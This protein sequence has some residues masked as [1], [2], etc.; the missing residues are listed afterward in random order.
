MPVFSSFTFT[1][2][3]NKTDINV[4][5][6]DPDCTPR[7]I[8]QIAH[9]VA[10]HSG[11]YDGFMAFLAS[12]GFVAVAND[13]LGHG[14]SYKRIDEQGWFAEEDGWDL[15]VGDVKKLHDI[16]RKEFPD[17]PYVL[18]GHSMGSF[19]VRTYLIRYPGDADAA[20]IC[21]TGQQSPALVGAGK[22]AALLACRTRGTMR[23]SKALNAMAFGSYN[24][25]FEPRRTDFDWL[26]RDDAVVDA[27]IKDPNC[28]FAVT[29]GLFRDMMTG[30]EFISKPE[31]AAKMNKSLPVFF[32]SGDK[33]PVG[34]NGA[35]PQRAAELFRSAGM[36]DV[37]LKLYSDCRHELLNEINRCDVMDDILKFIESRI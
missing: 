2:T 30:I 18:F 13:H 17:L 37:T 4:R 7:G 11:R 8:V 27:Y 32:I 31:N 9:G 23:R 20:I 14:G 33:D 35:G 26:T 25:D 28:G 10:E 19:I 1:S 12:H 15:V 34:E 24:R 22:A 5:R 6:F 36:R 16:M 21:G 3:N 29:A